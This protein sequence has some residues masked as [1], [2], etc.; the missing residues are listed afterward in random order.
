LQDRVEDAKW[1]SEAEKAL[2]AKNIQAESATKNVMSFY[3]VLTHPLIWLMTLIYFSFVM[4]LYGIGFWMPSIIK[5]TGVTDLLGI[6]MLSAIPYAAATIVMI[7]IG[8]SADQHRERRWHI[9]IPALL[10][11]AGLLL[12][13]IYGENTLIAICALTL[14]TSGILTVLALFWSLPTAIL[15]GLGAAA[16]IALVNSFGNVAGFVSPYLVGWLKDLTHNTDIGMIM[17]SVSLLVG[18]LLTLML[19]KEMVDK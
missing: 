1:L 10:A 17:L 5:S 15:S 2:I 19:P 3:Q 18:A 7:L 4:G 12:V 13:T 16:G 9:A 8:K 14:A 6:G 11:S